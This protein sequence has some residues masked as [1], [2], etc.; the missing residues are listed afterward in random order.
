MSTWH[1]GAPFVR[2]ELGRDTLRYRPFAREGRRL[3][4][5]YKIAI[6]QTL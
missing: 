5:D 6:C 4:V 1:V 2:H 3:L